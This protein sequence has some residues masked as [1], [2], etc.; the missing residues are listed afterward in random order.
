MGYLLGGMTE[1]WFVLSLEGRLC[2]AYL[3]GGKGKSCCFVWF[4]MQNLL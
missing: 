1:P 2:E 3:G 4:E